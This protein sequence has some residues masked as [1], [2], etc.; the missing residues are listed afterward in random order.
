MIFK[1][2]FLGSPGLFWKLSWASP[3][4]ALAGDGAAVWEA[5]GQHRGALGPGARTGP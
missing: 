2:W 1:K 5:A 4:T 3:V